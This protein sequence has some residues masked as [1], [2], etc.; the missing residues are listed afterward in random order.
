MPKLSTSISSAPPPLKPTNYGTGGQS[1]PATVAQPQGL[2]AYDT[3]F[4]I[5]QTSSPVQSTPSGGLSFDPSKIS[6]TTGTSPKSQPFDARSDLMSTIV[7]N[8]TTPNGG[9]VTLGGDG[10]VHGHTPAAGFKIDTNSQVPSNYLVPQGNLQQAH[11]AYSDLVNGVAA[12]QGYSPQYL[13]ALNQQYAAQAQ[14]AQLSLNQAGINSALVSRGAPTTQDYLSNPTLYNAGGV[15][16][17]AQALNA[18]EQNTNSMAQ[19]VNAVQQLAANQAL[20]TQQ[21]ARTG[22][23]SSAQTQ[24]QY[25]PA[26]ISGQNALSQANSL[27]QSHPDA[28]I[29]PYA[30]SGMTPEQYQQ[31]AMQKVAQS[32]SYRAQFQSTFTTPGGGTGIRNALD[33]S[34]LPKNSDGTMSLVTGAAA[35]AGSSAASNYNALA[36]QVNNLSVPYKAAND[37]FTAMLDYMDQAGINDNGIPA[38]DQIKNKMDAGLLAPG[39]QGKFQT[40]IQSLRAKYAT[41]LGATGENPNAAT[42][43]ATSLIPDR[44]GRADMEMIRD[45]LNINGQNIINA[46]QSRA[47]ELYNSLSGGTPQSNP[48]LGASSAPNVANSWNF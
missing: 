22:A 18:Q 33:S 12:A 45:G 37:D 43:N 5:G 23:I 10:T 30:Q 28:G 38:I 26:G 1:S 3:S 21:L 9:T 36:T 25:S 40:Y 6:P 13:G 39:A 8:Y 7:K 46:T 34:S 14:G 20:N 47:A 24:L 27:Q 41:L 2:S 4:K 11:S 29:V 32:P 42:D 19:G 48:S 15:T 17:Q 16:S 35:A 44:L 31:Y